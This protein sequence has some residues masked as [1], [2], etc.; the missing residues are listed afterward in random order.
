MASSAQVEVT[1]HWELAWCGA[2]TF[3]EEIH[4]A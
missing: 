1:D 4:H 2:R 3:I